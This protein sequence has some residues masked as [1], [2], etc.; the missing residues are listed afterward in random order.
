MS[1]EAKI[2]GEKSDAIWL[3]QGKNKGRAAWWFVF[4][5]PLKA[6]MLKRALQTGTFKVTDYGDVIESGFG[7][8]PGSDDIDNVLKKGY[9][10]DKSLIEG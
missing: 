4:V 9:K 1:F 8:K 3:I 6:E 5:K 2:L 7:D 10:L